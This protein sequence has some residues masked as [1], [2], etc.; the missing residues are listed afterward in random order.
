MSEKPNCYEC[1]YI[2][3]VPGSAHNS[4]HHPTV[5]ANKLSPLSEVMAIL[6]VPT[7][8]MVKPSIELN[9]TGDAHGVSKGWFMWPVNYD[10]VWLLTCNGFT[11]KEEK[12]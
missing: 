12:K 11:P 4:C 9:V 7:L 3:S 5:K 2:G 10:P 8:E 1:K 6:G